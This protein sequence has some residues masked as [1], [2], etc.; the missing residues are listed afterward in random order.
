M[1][2][3]LTFT[4]IWI[5]LLPCETRLLPRI[6]YCVHDVLPKVDIYL[7]RFPLIRTR[8]LSGFLIVESATLLF[9]ILR[10][11]HIGEESCTVAR[12]DSFYADLLA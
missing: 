6:K 2:G 1:L 3:P 4:C 7:S 11:D 12:R 9:V 5:T 8:L 10:V